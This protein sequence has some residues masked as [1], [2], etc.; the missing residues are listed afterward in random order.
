V[1]AYLKNNKILVGQVAKRQNVI[2][3]NNTFY[4]IKRFIGS[5]ITDFD[6]DTL[7]MPYKIIKGKDS[8]IE[9]DCPILNRTFR[10]EEISAQVL[11]K[12]SD[13]AKQYTGE[14]VDKAVITVPA[15]FND[16][17]RQA[18]QDAGKIAGLEVLRIINEPT[19]ASLAYGLE[20]NAN[21]IILV[22][23]LGGGTFDVSVLE[24][25]DGLFEVL[26]TSGDTSLGGDN[27]DELVIKYL[28]NQFK[29]KEG[30]DLST[31]PQAL[32]RIVE[33]A[34]RAKIELSN[35]TVTNISLPFI[36]ADSK[37][38]KHLE[39]EFTQE[40][41]NE[42]CSSLIQRCRIPVANALK[43]S[44]TSGDRV[45]QVVLVGGSTRIPAVQALIQDIF[46]ATLNQ[47]VNPDEVVA[48]GAAIQAGVICGEVKDILL[49]DV[50]PLSLGVETLGGVFSRMIPRN[51]TIPT[52]TSQMFSTAMNNQANVEIRVF[53]GEREFAKDNTSLGVFTLTGIEP[54]PRATPQIEVTFDIDVNGILSVKALDKGTGS[55]QEITISNASNLDQKDIDEMVA[56]AAEF[57][58]T[59][60]EKRE[61]ADL[62]NEVDALCYS[63]DTSLADASI[64]DELK[65]KA[66]SK[67]DAARDALEREDCD[68]VRSELDALRQISE[69][70]GQQ[71]ETSSV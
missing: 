68:S 45:N 41:F 51:T 22:F 6:A 4:S 24:V 12:L 11:S 5:K 37:G 29:E 66:R 42:L 35:V 1:V 64:S 65:E 23:D 63:V 50:T 14:I 46:G 38:P 67:I 26:S 31:D 70:I 2:N 39:I 16:S 57:A 13:D 59:D 55:E 17:Q 8:T 32:Q 47:S 25:G 71:S 10:P 7:K 15:Y 40:K 9:L 53:Q 62:T 52:K 43:D 18:T 30:V 21:E 19:A 61:L 56:S 49:L 60:K 69:D 48:V 54:A 36:T 3:P 34:E 58:E 27:F 28:L 44:N 20:K 33:A